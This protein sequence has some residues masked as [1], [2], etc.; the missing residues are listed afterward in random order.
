MNVLKT[1]SR[2]SDCCCCSELIKMNTL[3][4]DSRAGKFNEANTQDSAVIT[5]LS[6]AMNQISHGRHSNLL[7]SSLLSIWAFCILFLYM[8][9][10][11]RFLPTG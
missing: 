8:H 6:V 3:H 5:V 7:P 11:E 10:Y 4:E 2:L 9:R 1:N